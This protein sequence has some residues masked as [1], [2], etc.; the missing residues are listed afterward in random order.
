MTN[1]DSPQKLDPEEEA[2]VEEVFDLL[3]LN[4][5][6]GAKDP[7]YEI[8]DDK[9]GREAVASALAKRLAENP[10]DNFESELAAI[11]KYLDTRHL[12]P[13]ANKIIVEVR[14]E[15]RRAKKAVAT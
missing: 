13:L 7:D 12:P 3:A 14:V 11:K 8:P 15:V 4:L 10:N 1:D 6:H 5:Q 2:L 9:S